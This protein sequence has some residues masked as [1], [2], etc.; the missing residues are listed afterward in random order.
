MAQAMIIRRGSA[1]GGG[2]DPSGVKVIT[3]SS[4]SNLPSSETEG[5]IAAITSVLPN[6]VIISPIAPETS[7]N[8]DVFV[9]I[10]SR[11]GTLVEVILGS[12]RMSWY[13]I[14]V[15]QYIAAWVKIDACIMH[16]GNWVPVYDYIYCDGRFKKHSLIFTRNTQ[17]NG[18]IDFLD[19]YVDW[20]WGSTTARNQLAYAPIKLNVTALT[21]ILLEIDITQSSAASGIKIVMGLSTSKP[22]TYTPPSFTAS[23]DTSVLGKQTL[24]L[25]VSSLS[26]EYYLV[27]HGG[28]LTAKMYKVLYR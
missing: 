19:E 16:D 15:Y 28:A 7:Q 10:D 21:E 25:N 20:W 8:N 11:G 4:I 5:T 3:A 14:A 24:V 27:F 1:G 26:G 9:E 2:A 23:V 6:T 18:H 13:P 12:T 22:T 17:E